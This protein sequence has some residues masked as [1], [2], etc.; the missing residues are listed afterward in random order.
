MIFWTKT[1]ILWYF[2]NSKENKNK[3]IGNKKNKEKILFKMR[4]ELLNLK[5]I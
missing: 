2:V 3:I 4:I 5:T 1:T